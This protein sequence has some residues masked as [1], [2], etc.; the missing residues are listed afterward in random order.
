MVVES[1]AFIKVGDGVLLTVRDGVPRGVVERRLGEAE[2]QP[3]VRS[4][5]TGNVELVLLPGDEVEDRT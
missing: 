1:K 5:G 4:D 3:V 2:R